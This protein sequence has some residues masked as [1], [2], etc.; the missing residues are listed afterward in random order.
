MKVLVVENEKTNQDKIVTMLSDLGWDLLKMVENIEQASAYLIE[1]TPDLIIAN[2][3]LGNEPHLQALL[4]DAEKQN[5][6]VLLLIPSDTEGQPYI[7]F[8]LK[9]LHKQ[10]LKAVANLVLPNIL[11]KPIK[12]QGIEVRGKQQ[13]KKTIPFED[14]LWIS[15]ERNYCFLKTDNSRYGLKTSL[16][17][18]LPLL[19]KRFIQI[20]R[21]CVVNTH[22]I[23]SVKI[24]QQELRIKTTILPIGRLFKNELLIYLSERE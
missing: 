22:Y 23:D 11:L 1:C 17:Q 12:P 16:S 20:H 21:G 6:P 14:I 10:S 9:P 19:D 3:L 7:N 2:M 15:V 4:V 18:L 13:Q 8:L 5:V 24:S